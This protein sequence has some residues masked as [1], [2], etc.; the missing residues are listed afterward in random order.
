LPGKQ[1]NE[2]W[3]RPA[4]FVPPETEGQ[5]KLSGERANRKLAYKFALCR[6]LP[7]G[8]DMICVSVG[9]GFCLIDPALS[10]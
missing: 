5:E 7:F 2:I 8:E 4:S 3:Q 1:Q 9:T 6:L 10:C